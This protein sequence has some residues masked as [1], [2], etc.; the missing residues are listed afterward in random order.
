MTNLDVAYVPTPKGIVRQMLL[1]ARLRRDELLY[2]LGAGD[3]RILIE[4]ARSFGARCVGV[5]IDPVR[6]ARLKERLEATRVM[7][8]VIEG[9]LM[10]VDL[11]KADV[12][13]IYLSNSVNSKLAPKLTRELKPGSRVVSLDYVLP[14]WDHEKELIVKSTALDRKLYLYITK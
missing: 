9:D 13:T 10:N 12:V 1:L 2:D 4:A 14:E 7:A 5:E 3:G 11:S 6:I 8:E